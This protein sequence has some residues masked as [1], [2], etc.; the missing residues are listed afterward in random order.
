ML[1]AMKLRWWRTDQAALVPEPVSD[2][3]YRDGDLACPACRDARVRPYRGRH[4]CDRCGGIQLALSDLGDALRDLVGIDP[5]LAFIEEQ[6]GARRC[7]Q[8]KLPM[9]TCHVTVTI[10][11]DRIKTKPTLDRCADHGIWFD[12][13]ELASVLERVHRKHAKL[14]TPSPWIGFGGRGPRWPGG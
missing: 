3:P 4:V 11:D 13:D 12:S 1:G 7:P 14:H 6:P 8:C 9:T 2:D 10:E 5:T